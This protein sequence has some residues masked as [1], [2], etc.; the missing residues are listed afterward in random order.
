MCVC[1]KS[2]GDRRTVALNRAISSSVSCSRQ[3][4]FPRSNTALTRSSH[5]AQSAKT[6]ESPEALQF[7]CTWH[8]TRGAPADRKLPCRKAILTESLEEVRRRELP[9]EENGAVVDVENSAHADQQDLQASCRGGAQ[10]E[11][12]A[13]RDGPRRGRGKAAGGG[14]GT[15]RGEGPRYSSRHNTR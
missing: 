4:P 12:E 1:G 10:T 11:A 7:C 15:H 3:R 2:P 13:W 6:R 14:A 5:P 9:V 8:E